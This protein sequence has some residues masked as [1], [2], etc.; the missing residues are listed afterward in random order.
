MTGRT[1]RAVIWRIGS[2]AVNR[3]VGRALSL[4]IEAAPALARLAR[5]LQRRE[6]SAPRV[7]LSL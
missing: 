1:T 3:S 2:I 7:A 4:R 6:L 5:L